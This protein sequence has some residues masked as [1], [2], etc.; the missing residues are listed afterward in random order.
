MNIKSKIIIASFLFFTSV[1]I[2]SQTAKKQSSDKLTEIFRFNGITYSGD[3]IFGIHPNL[4]KTVEIA[5][6]LMAQDNTSKDRLKEL[7]ISMETFDKKKGSLA[8]NEFKRLY[9][10]GYKLVSK[11]EFSKLTSI[12]KKELLG[13]SSPPLERN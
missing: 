9:P 11:E 3:R 6:S 13:S 12:E 2:Q 10:I 4:E 7:K 5:M 8:F 1:N